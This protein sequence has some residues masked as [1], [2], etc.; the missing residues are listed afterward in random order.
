MA[1]PV[2]NPA[3]VL[4]GPAYL[5]T[6]VANTALVA[7]TL[8]FN[9]IWTAPWSY[10]G[11]TTEGVAFASNVNTQNHDIE[12][13]PNPALVALT[14]ADYTITATL[15][16]DL[17][18]KLVIALG[19]GLIT[20]VAAA[21]GVPGTQEWNPGLTL[22]QY[23]VGFEGINTFGFWRRFY[24]A[25]ANSVS[26]PTVNYRRAAAPRQFATTFHAICPPTGIRIIGQNAA[27][28]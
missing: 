25:V 3:N 23:A 13:Q 11:A 21:T 26:N 7:N 14:S 17:L 15:A 6:A 4:V 19:H 24:F 9:T 16:E 1:P 10:I 8:A 18:D 20:T 22:N 2:P 5:Y 12:E 28:L 27:A